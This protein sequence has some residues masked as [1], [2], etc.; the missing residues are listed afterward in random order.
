[1]V[2]LQLNAFIRHAASVRMANLAQLVNVLA[3]IFTSPEGMFLQPIFFPLEVY[4]RTCGSTA[5][6]AYWTGDTF[7]GGSHTALRVLDVAAALDEGKKSLSVYVVNRSQTD[8][9]ETTITLEAG[10]FAG[11]V[12]AYVV[13]AA[14]IK[15]E[16][17]FANPNQVG[18]TESGYTADKQSSFTYTFEPHSSTALVFAL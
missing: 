10:S 13:N 1:V 14:D 17:T 5:L 3:P 18:T 7:S 15:A 4:S 9:M 8:A 12:R 16:N 11:V 6:D 2:A